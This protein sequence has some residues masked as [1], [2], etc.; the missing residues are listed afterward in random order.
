MPKLVRQMLRIPN[1]RRGA[2]RIPEKPLDDRLLIS[3]AGTWV[4]PAYRKA[5]D[6][7]SSFL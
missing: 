1:E 7:C 3:A 6:A 5:C 4:V 2:L